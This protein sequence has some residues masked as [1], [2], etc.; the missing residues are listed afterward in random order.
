MD[1]LREAGVILVGGHSIND[2]EIKFGFAVTGAIRPD[3][4]VANSGA[5]PGDAMILTKPIGT[6]IISFAAQ[7]GRASAEAL[8]AAGE[9]H[10]RAQP[11]ARRRSCAAPA[12]T[13]GPMSPASGCSAISG[14]S[15]ARA[16]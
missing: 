7:I 3:A 11:R 10:G 8:R 16:A 9:T 15:R 13:R 5:R 4:I 6:G 12:R 2:E 14:R 1:K